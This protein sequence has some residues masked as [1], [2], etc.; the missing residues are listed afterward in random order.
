MPVTLRLLAPRHPW[1]GT[2]LDWIIAASFSG[3]ANRV[4]LLDLLGGGQELDPVR[5][6]DLAL[7]L[8]GA[9]PFSGPAVPIAA[10]DAASAVTRIGVDVSQTLQAV[11]HTAARP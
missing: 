2:A 10:Q 3:A 1:P 4:Q 11:L 7:T 8:G 9:T 5:P 6:P